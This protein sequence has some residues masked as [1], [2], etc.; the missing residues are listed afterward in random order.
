MTKR[1]LVTLFALNPY[2]ELERWIE[3]KRKPGRSPP[4]SIYLEG[5]ND[6]CQDGVVSAVAD[7]TWY[8]SSSSFYYCFSLKRETLRSKLVSISNNRIKNW[9]TRYS[10]GRRIMN[11][12]YE[13]GYQSWQ[14]D[15]DLAGSMV[16]GSLSSSSCCSS[17]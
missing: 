10:R 12:K 4:L 9:R 5:G 15:A 7:P 13:G 3:L 16:Y 17:L 6:Q 14:G 1:P 11:E 2:I 8:G